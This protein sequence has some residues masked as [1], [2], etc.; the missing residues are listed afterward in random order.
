MYPFVMLVA[1]GSDD[2]VTLGAIL[3]DLQYHTC[4]CIFPADK[5]KL[6]DKLKLLGPTARNE[7]TIVGTRSQRCCMNVNGC[8]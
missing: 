8:Q 1:L 2:F 5:V 3:D 4:H 6:L 7:T